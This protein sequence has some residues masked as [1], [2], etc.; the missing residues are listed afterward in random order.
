MSFVSL[1]LHGLK[2][3]L[4][5]F[6]VLMVGLI[7]MLIAGSKKSTLVNNVDYSNLIED[8]INVNDKSIM[9]ELKMCK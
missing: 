8:I 9:N 2:R 5:L 6:Q 4:I 3:I 1:V 7:S